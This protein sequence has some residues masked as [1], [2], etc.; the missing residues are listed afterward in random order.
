MYVCMCV[1]VCVC[2]CVIPAPTCSEIEAVDVVALLAD[3]AAHHEQPGGIRA[4]T[5]RAEPC[6]TAALHRTRGQLCNMLARDVRNN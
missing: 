5:T 1:C 4:G 6:A 3:K 2:V